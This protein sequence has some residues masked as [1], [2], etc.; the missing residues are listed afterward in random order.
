MAPN[1]D[2]VPPTVERHLL[3]HERHVLTVRFHP[4][5]LLAPFAAAG[6]GLIAA[7]VLSFLNLSG[8][9]LAIT[10]SAWGLVM[11]HALWRAA[12][13]LEEYFVVTPQRVLVIRGYLTRDV[14]TV[15]VSAAAEFRFRRSFLGRL[16]GY[17][18]FTFE[19]GA[20]D[21]GIRTVSFLPYP[22]Q[23]YLE[24]M[25]LIFKDRGEPD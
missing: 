5:V 16:L 22:E 13:W 3:P 1:F 21:W 24:V 17:G 8:D 14:L 10:W 12:R 6:G 18:Q 25:G 20:A 23:L 11:L 4:A 2:R 15:P 9:A 19:G 7:S